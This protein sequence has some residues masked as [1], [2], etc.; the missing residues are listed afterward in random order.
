MS[1]RRS[2]DPKLDELFQ[3][4]L[5]EFTGTRDA[6]VAELRK[7]GQ[8]GAAADL[9]AIKKPSVS[10]WA[11]NQLFFHEAELWAKLAEAGAALRRAYGAM[12]QSGAADAVRKAQKELGRALDLLRVKARAVLQSNRQAASETMLRR[13]ATTLHALAVREPDDQIQAGRLTADVDPPGFETLASAF[14]EAA[15]KGKAALPAPVPSHGKVPS[16]P[17]TT[18]QRAPKTTPQRA[19]QAKPAPAPAR[20]HKKE[21]A[22][23]AQ[24]ERE[25]L[26]RARKTA[27][28]ALRK[29]QRELADRT[30][31]LAAATRKVAAAEQALATAEAAREKAAHAQKSA[32]EALVQAES[33]VDKTD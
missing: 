27:E 10:A 5:A 11:V 24:K 18:P 33:A 19:A 14:G 23:A 25:R 13:V 2:A 31:A 15:P 17:K 12:G 1:K 6:L 20:E 4:P 8:T 32:K 28:A 30:R 16:A 29:A 7:K 9:K 3:A 21:L 26:A 22:R